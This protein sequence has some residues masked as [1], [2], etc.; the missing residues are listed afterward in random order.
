MGI[1]LTAVESLKEQNV[2]LTQDETADLMTNLLVVTCGDRDV[3]V[4]VVD[5][6]LTPPPPPC[7]PPDH[8]TENAN[9]FKAEPKVFL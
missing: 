5:H 3:G 7:S 6:F 8:F 4:A 2:K 9:Y 1:A